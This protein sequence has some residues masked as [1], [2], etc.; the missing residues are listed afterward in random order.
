M[1]KKLSFDAESFFNLGRE[2]D[3]LSVDSS[4]LLSKR[5]SELDKSLRGDAQLLFEAGEKINESYLKS[6]PLE[7]KYISVLQE[8]N[9]M[10]KVSEL[11]SFLKL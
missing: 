11:T 6:T 9:L 7:D 5:F 2:S 10:E 4:I 8:Y 1:S 3:D